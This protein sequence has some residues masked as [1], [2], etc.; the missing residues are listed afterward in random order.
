MNRRYPRYPDDA[1]Y[2]TNSP[3][4]YEDLAR[5]QKLF[6]MLSER[7]WEYDKEIAE[8][9]RRW[10]ENLETINKDVIRM[11]IQW[12]DDGTLDQILN[13]ELLNMKP[14]IYLSEEEPM[15]NFPNTY[16]YHD[17]GLSGLQQNIF[18]SNVIVSDD[19]PEDE[20]YN[21]WLDY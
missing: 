6:K 11:M 2:Q 21:I 15:T 4:Y 3:S 18:K 5:L 9:F 20:Q 16:W 12:L 19:E 17:V 10:E 13:E 7:I 8:Y 14:E 1:D